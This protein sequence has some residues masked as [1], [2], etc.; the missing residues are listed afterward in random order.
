MNVLIYSGD[1]VS[2]VALNH[3]L[4]SLQRVLR[5]THAVQTITARQLATSPW[6]KNCAMLVMPGGRDKGY[7]EAGERALSRINTF[8]REHGGSY[9]GLCAGA[10]FASRQ[11]VFE[12]GRPGYEVCGER[13][14]GFFP[15]T[16]VG[17]VLPGFKYNSE[18]GAHAAELINGT[19]SKSCVYYNGGCRFVPDSDA[20]DIDVLARYAHDQTPAIVFMQC[21]RGKVVLSGVHLEYDPR[22]LTEETAHNVKSALIKDDETRVF[23]F[24]SILTVLLGKSLAIS[25]E[26]QDLSDRP[27]SS[28]AGHVDG[29]GRTESRFFCGLEYEKALKTKRFGKNLLLTERIGSTQTFLQSDAATTA[30]LPPGTAVLAAEQTAGRGRGENKWISPPPRS[31]LQ[32]SFTFSHRHLPSLSL[33]QCVAAAAMIIGIREFGTGKTEPRAFIKW[34]NDLYIKTGEICGRLAAFSSTRRR[35]A[36]RIIQSSSDVV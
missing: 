6:E 28:I 30:K 10:Y 20:K 21:G 32:F 34:P 1:G 8:V 5:H 27:I 26:P 35:S 13:P 33:L 22:K 12:S 19:G 11:I 25:S 14:F 23:L 9:L 2:P 15:G 17:T 24:Q 3:A 4:W 7:L 16:A 29:Y 31:S 36:V 18:E